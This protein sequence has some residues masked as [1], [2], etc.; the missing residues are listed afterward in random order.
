MTN[1][2]DLHRLGVEL[3]NLNCNSASMSQAKG[4]GTLDSLS[5]SMGDGFGPASTPLN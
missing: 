2:S 4:P 1:P 3:Y 5:M